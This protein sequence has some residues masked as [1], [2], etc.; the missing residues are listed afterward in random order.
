MQFFTTSMK[1]CIIFM[2]LQTNRIE[3][4]N[5][6]MKYGTRNIGRVESAFQVNF[7]DADTGRKWG[8]LADTDNWPNTN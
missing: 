5:I 1:W 6:F 3:W 8:I 4:H 7:T 2:D